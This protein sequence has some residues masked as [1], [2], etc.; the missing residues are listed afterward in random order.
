M[1]KVIDIRVRDKIA[2]LVNDD[3]TIVC[4]NDDYVVAFD[5]DDEWN[6]YEY[7]TAF[8]TNAITSVPVVFEGNECPVPPQNDVLWLAVGVSAGDIRT[9]TSALVPCKKSAICGVKPGEPSPDV[10]AQIMNMMN[11]IESTGCVSKSIVIEE[12]NPDFVGAGCYHFKVFKY[13]ANQ[14]NLNVDMNT[15]AVVGGV[16]FRYTCNM[17]RPFGT[18]TRILFQPERVMFENESKKGLVEHFRAYEKDAGNGERELW[19]EIKTV[20]GV[21]QELHTNLQINGGMLSDTELVQ[22][23]EYVPFKSTSGFD[24]LTVKNVNLANKTSVHNVD[25]HATAQGASVA[26]TGNRNEGK[27]SYVDGSGNLNKASNS[28][29]FGSDNTNEGALSLISGTRN[30]NKA[31][32][33]V[34]VGHTNTNEGQHVF[35]HGHENHNDGTGGNRCDYVDMHGKRLNASRRL[36]MVRGQYN[37][38]DTR[39]IAVWGNGSSESSRKNVFS[40]AADGNPTED[41]DGVTVASLRKTLEDFA[42]SEKEKTEIVAGTNCSNSGANSVVVGNGNK[43]TGSASAVFGSTNNNGAALSLLS[44]TKNTN[45]GS[46]S[47]MVGHTN[48]NTGQHVFIHGYENH[49]DGTGENRCD[50]VD[51]HG[52]QLLAKRRLQM[53]RGQYN[54]EDTRAL[55]LWGNGTS[56]GRKNVFAV[57]ASG[58]PEK[59]YDG[60]T[61]GYLLDMFAPFGKLPQ[62]D[63]RRIGEDGMGFEAVGMYPSDAIYIFHVNGSLRQATTNNKINGLSAYDTVS[64]RVFA[65]GYLTSDSNEHE[66]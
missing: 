63:L 1:G 30:T 11:N 32:N 19:V 51:M 64:V 58:I 41:T 8:F 20:G 21:V 52:T 36:Q 7:K 65:R 27:D 35:I 2:E 3:V 38:E 13:A 26:G 10:Y 39:A 31:S 12:W 43:N 14:S 55:A 59:N 46:N 4:N 56:S 66:V 22:A 33:V 24:S 28:A 45:T 44:G 15:R 53:V 60:V 54:E 17:Q 47:V 61:L 18:S 42:P 50:Y 9:S 25:S 16:G 37:K 5:F 29:V 23:T 34:M 62:P 48:S 6:E 40:I 49:N 57:P